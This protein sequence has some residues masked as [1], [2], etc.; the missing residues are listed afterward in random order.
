V[1]L[2][3][4]F[5][6]KRG[7]VKRTAG[8]GYSGAQ[9]GRLYA[10]W[11]LGYK[12]DHNEDIKGNLD[13]LR[14]RAVD[15]FDNND[16]VK[17][18]VKLCDRNIVGHEGMILQPQ[19]K[20]TDGELD[21][22]ANKKIAS[23][24]WDWGRRKKYAS[25]TRKQTFLDIQHLAIKTA[26]R[27]GEAL[28]RMV[29]GFDNPYRFA[30]QMIPPALLP[31]MLNKPDMPGGHKVVMG[32]EY[33]E[34]DAP[35]MYYVKQKTGAK[36]AAVIDGNY[37]LKIPANEI[38]HLY[39]Q[40]YINQARGVPWL[41]TAMHRLKMLDGYE[42][43]E[44][45]AARI[46]ACQ[47]GLIKTETGDEFTGNDT[48]ALGNTI[49][50]AEPGT[51]PELP[52]GQSMDMFKPE[53]PTTQFPTFVKMLMLAIASGGDVA[54]SSMTGDL[55]KV[56]YSSIRAGLL[57]ERDAWKVLQQ[58]FATHFCD[59]IFEAWLK[60]A[61]LT[62]KLELP[63]EKFEKFNDVYW[64]GRGWDWV[65]PLKDIQAIIKAINSGLT[66][67]TKEANKRGM[68]VEELF[69]EIANDRK[70]AEKF[71]LVFNMDGEAVPVA[72]NGEETQNEE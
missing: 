67:W 31:V 9:A 20:D 62:R 14:R 1:K 25:V 45:V 65:D 39:I 21:T 40:E 3:D 38:V 52:A 32:V 42:D 19:A 70:L 60:M 6:A 33:D 4:K 17:K 16:W 47:M 22:M 44:L 57:D 8:R 48:D 23:A 55:E 64:Q 7:Y 15:L 27:E 41:H 2:L 61:L 59:D 50:E 24:F 28:V 12:D 63:A 29:S 43:A 71:G 30:L 56:N 34:W 51:F 69:E 46:A 26:A 18:F 68:D 10:D 11:V 5:L 72:A 36:D 58:W 49:I 35:F 66:S 13:V 37:Y 53:H 54:Y